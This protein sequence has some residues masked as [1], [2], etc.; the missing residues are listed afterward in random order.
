MGCL[1]IIKYDTIHNR[2]R[3]KMCAILF[4]IWAMTGIPKTRKEFPVVT[5]QSLIAAFIETRMF[6][7][8]KAFAVL[9]I[10]YS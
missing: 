8:E 1:V 2:H 9:R 4:H 7:P 5:F 10:M 6:H 3:S